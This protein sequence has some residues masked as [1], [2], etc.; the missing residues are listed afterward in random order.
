MNTDFC[1]ASLRKLNQSPGQITRTVH[2]TPRLNV[3]RLNAVK[4]EKLV[5][6]AI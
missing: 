1:D 5:E 6:G 4:E 2:Q 3:I